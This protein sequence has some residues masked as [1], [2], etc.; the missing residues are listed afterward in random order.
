MDTTELKP[1]PFCGHPVDMDDPDTLYP[2]PTGFRREEHWCY[3][4]Q[5]VETAGGCGAEIS[6]DS[7]QECIDKWNRRT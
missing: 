3:T 7:E 2:Y 5:C 4:I 1:C 6:A